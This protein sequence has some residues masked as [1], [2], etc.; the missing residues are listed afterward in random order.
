MQPWL[1]RMRLATAQ[2]LDTL[3]G[4]RT[5]ELLMGDR[6]SLGPLALEIVRPQ[7][8]ECEIAQVSVGALTLPSEIRRLASEVER[9]RLEGLVALERT[10]G[11]HAALRS[12]ANA[13]RLKKGN[14]ELMNLRVLQALPVGGKGA[15]LVLGRDGLVPMRPVEESGTVGDA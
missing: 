5:L 3:A 12:L 7:I 14:P 8:A 13:A 10:R 2:A 15:T 6:T 4:D 11:E 9:A 1:E